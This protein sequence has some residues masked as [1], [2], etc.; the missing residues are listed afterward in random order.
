[1]LIALMILIKLKE[2]SMDAIHL[3][4]KALPLIIRVLQDCEIDYEEQADYEGYELNIDDQAA[5]FAFRK[6][7]DM[8]K[9]MNDDKDFVSDKVGE[10]DMCE[11]MDASQQFRISALQHDLE[12]FIEFKDDD[13]EQDYSS[14]EII[15]AYK[16]VLKMMMIEKD[17]VNYIKTLDV[18]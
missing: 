13:E 14:E 4:Y 2:R 8:L 5:I 11:I 18:A 16:K 10:L 15:E 17:Y 1:M 3:K 9:T 12:L 7:V 6:V